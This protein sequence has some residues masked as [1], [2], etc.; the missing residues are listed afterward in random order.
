MNWSDAQAGEG[1][2][3]DADW[4]QGRVNGDAASSPMLV[5]LTGFQTTYLMSSPLPFGLV[6]TTDTW[7]GLE[8]A[9][10]DQVEEKTYDNCQIGS[11]ITPSSHLHCVSTGRSV[12]KGYQHG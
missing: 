11:P 12:E 4:L 2:E 3:L 7:D 5:V 10:T 9:Y 6:I 1:E 8:G